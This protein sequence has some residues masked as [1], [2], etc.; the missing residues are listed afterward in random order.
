MASLGMEK[1]LEPP[2]PQA[3][4][5]KQELLNMHRLCFAISDGFYNITKTDKGLQCLIYL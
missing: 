3:S 4:L 5:A 2:R 1:G